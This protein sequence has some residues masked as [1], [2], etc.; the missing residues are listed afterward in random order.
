M[1]KD[2]TLLKEVLLEA[3]EEALFVKQDGCDDAIL[4]IAYRFG[5]P[6]VVA[7]DYEGCLDAF[8][9]SG[10]TY[11]E[12]E[13]HMSVNVIGSYLGESIPVFID[14]RYLDPH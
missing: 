9:A 5:M 4:G 14:R 3:N 11:E 1:K 6:P 12:A 13:E 10:M 8:I 2:I 7:Y